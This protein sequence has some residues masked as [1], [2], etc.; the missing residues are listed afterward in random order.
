[1]RDGQGAW[2]CS[3]HFFTSGAQSRFLTREDLVEYDLDGEGYGAAPP[4]PAT[5]RL[6]AWKGEAAF[7]SA[8][9]KPNQSFSFTFRAAGSYTYKDELHPK[10]RGTILVKGAPPTLTLAASAKYVVAGDKLTLTGIVS[11][12]LAGEQVAIFYQPYPMPTSRRRVVTQQKNRPPVA[13]CASTVAR[14]SCTATPRSRD[15]VRR[16]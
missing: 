12:H 15:R 2:S 13:H 4:G 8:I 16:G 6:R 10:I 9:L 7:V 3:F 5:G 1:M 11:N 14:S